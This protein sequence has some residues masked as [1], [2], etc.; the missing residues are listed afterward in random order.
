MTVNVLAGINCIQVTVKK[1]IAEGKKASIVNI[2]SQAAL[3]ASP[4]ALGYSVSKACVDM[5]TK[6]FA[7]EHGP[8]NIRVN[9]INQTAVMGGMKDVLD[10]EFDVE[11]TRVERTPLGRIATIDEIVGPVLYL[12]SDYSAMV[13]GTNH[14][15]DGGIACNITTKQ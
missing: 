14:I 2:S 6:Q 12:L 9:S 10:K 3:R 5:V 8:H 4:M 1:M 13:T 11:K 7:L 15:V